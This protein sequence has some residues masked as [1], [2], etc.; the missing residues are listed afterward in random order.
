MGDTPRRSKWDLTPSGEINTNDA[1]PRGGRI[2]AT[3]SRFTNAEGVTPIANR[4]S[5][6]ATPKSGS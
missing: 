5:Q 2:T 3:P 6:S 1:T 4:W